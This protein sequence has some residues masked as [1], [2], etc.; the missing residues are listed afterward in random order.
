MNF[1]NKVVLVTGAGS[2]IGAAIAKGFSEN[3]AKLSLIDIN[4][5][6][7]DKTV[8][9]CK[10]KKVEVIKIIADLTKDEDVKRTI[11]ST[12]RKF[13]RIDI[14]VNCA[15]ICGSGSILDP[16]LLQKF[17]ETIAINLRTAIVVTN[18]VAPHLIE[19]KGNLINISSICA[20]LTTK[21]MVPYNVAKAGLTHFTKS[22]ALELADYGV[23]VNCISPGYVKTP[24]MLNSGISD[25]YI[26]AALKACAHIVPLKRVLEPEEIAAMAL[27]LASDKASGITGAD[28][29]VDGGL[30]L[31]GL[32]ALSEHKFY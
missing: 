14:V 31:T 22:A 2:G 30:L 23:R 1:N 28:Y 16:N 24:F 19:S 8:E 7:L 5:E 17:D 10:A 3:S 18:N 29:A 25:N 15:G 12:V 6:N 21:Y 4:E 9:A 32:N 26:D 13:D 27:F 11:D 20:T